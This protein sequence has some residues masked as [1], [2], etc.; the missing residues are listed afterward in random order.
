MGVRKGVTVLPYR[1]FNRGQ[2]VE[3]AGSM[4]RPSLF[5]DSLDHILGLG[6][7]KKR[8][9]MKS[10]EGDEMESFRFLEPLQTTRHAEIMTLELIGRPVH[11][12]KLR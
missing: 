9:P 4:T 1:T 3:R 2:L 7:F 8:K 5:Q 12:E 6:S 11:R 10:A